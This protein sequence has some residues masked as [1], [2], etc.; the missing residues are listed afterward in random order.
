MIESL[1]QSALYDSMRF[2]RK[3][4]LFFLFDDAQ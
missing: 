2:V 4:D 3:E 1:T